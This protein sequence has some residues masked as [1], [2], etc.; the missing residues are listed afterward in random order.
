MGETYYRR[1]IT[2]SCK[3]RLTDRGLG[4][5]PVLVEMIRWSARH[6]PDTPVTRALRRRLDRDTNELVTELVRRA[7]KGEPGFAAMGKD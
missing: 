6:D 4:L 3:F 2:I 7:R 5:I 1:W